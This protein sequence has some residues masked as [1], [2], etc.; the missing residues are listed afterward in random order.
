MVT[1]TGNHSSTVGTMATGSA[2]ETAAVPL[3]LQLDMI[4]LSPSPCPLSDP[5]RNLQAGHRRRNQGNG[6]V[7]E[8]NHTSELCVWLLRVSVGV[9]VCVGVRAFLCMC[10]RLG[11]L[12]LV[13]VYVCIYQ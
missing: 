10:L 5:N 13:F 2:L 6:H 1:G 8:P 9:Y 3:R 7:L 11:M 4:I 12:V